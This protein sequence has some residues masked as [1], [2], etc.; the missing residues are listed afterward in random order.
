MATLSFLAFLFCNSLAILP[1][2]PTPVS[3]DFRHLCSRLPQTSCSPLRRIVPCQILLHLPTINL[4]PNIL[5][6][7]YMDILVTFVL[8]TMVI[9]QDRFQGHVMCLFLFAS[10]VIGANHVGGYPN[11]YPSY[12]VLCGSLPYSS[13]P[14]FTLFILERGAVCEPAPWMGS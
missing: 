9:R 3:V 8:S 14:L 13:S 11:L 1:R 2:C 4:I 10:L 5:C 12:P 6:I 7:Y